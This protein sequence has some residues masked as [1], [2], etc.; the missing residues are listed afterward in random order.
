MVKVLSGNGIQSNKTVQSRSGVKVEPRT[1]A[2]NPAGI[3]QRDVSTAFRKENV[4]MGRGYELEKMPA[5][6]VAGKYN[7]ATSGPGSQRTVYR[8][9]SQ[10]PTPPAREMPA[11]RDIL[12]EYGRDIPGRGRR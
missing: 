5:T 10:G 6:G 2:I 9:G 1:T 3:S 12:S 7:A 11:G 8:S 4:E